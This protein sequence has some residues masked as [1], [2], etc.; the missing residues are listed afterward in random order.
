MGQVPGPTCSLGSLVPMLCDLVW[1]GSLS[2]PEWVSSY[3]EGAIRKWPQKPWQAEEEA[4]DEGLV[5]CTV[6]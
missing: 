4:P 1:S 6:R 3:L 5:D 2:E